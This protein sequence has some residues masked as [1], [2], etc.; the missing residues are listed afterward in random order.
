MAVSTTRR[1][2]FFGAGALPIGAHAASLGA[3]PP[4]RPARPGGLHVS[5]TTDGAILPGDEGRLLRTDEDV[6]GADITLTLP[7]A[8]A[9]GEGRRIRVRKAGRSHFTHIVTVAGDRIG[10]DGP[11]FRVLG[12]AD[13]GAGAIRLKVEEN[14]V[15]AADTRVVVEGVRGTVEANGEWTADRTPVEKLA[16]T[17][18]DLQGSAFRSPYISG[19]AV[20]VIRRRIS[21]LVQDQWI[22]LE[23][24]GVDRWQFFG[25]PGIE[26]SRDF[27]LGHNT[28]TAGG[29]K[30]FGRGGGDGIFPAD[31]V[32]DAAQLRLFARSIM[33]REVNDP[34]DLALGRIQANDGQ[35]SYPYGPKF[36]DFSEGQNI[37]SLYWTPFNHRIGFPRVAQIGCRSAEDHTPETLGVQLKMSVIPRG[38]NLLIDRLW[39]DQRFSWGGRS[40]DAAFNILDAAAGDTVRISNS[41]PAYSGALLRAVTAR[42]KDP[43]FQLIRFTANGDDAFRVDGAGNVATDGAA[44]MSTPADYA[45]MVREWWDG[46]PHGEDRAGLAVV[47][48]RRDRPEVVVMPGDDDHADSLIRPARTLGDPAREAIIGVVSVNPAI[49]G[50]SGELRWVRKFQTDPFGR[51]LTDPAEMVSWTEHR[52]ENTARA[53]DEPAFQAEAT[54]HAYYLDQLPPGVS[55]PPAPRGTLDEE[56]AGA[57][58]RILALQR[59]EAQGDPAAEGRF[60][61]TSAPAR[62][63]VA[64]PR[65]N[66]AFDPAAEYQGREQRR[67]WDFVGLVGRLPLRRGEPR[68]PRW[69]KTGDITPEVAEWLVR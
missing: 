65:L 60:T 27:L 7:P 34:V 64:R 39:I 6:R 16:L 51:V 30:G 56:I 36:S 17:H 20:T 57:R 10:E 37:G 21:L 48:V 55:V 11:R 2:M 38:S 29:Y 19:G 32:Y 12:A 63:P 41:S 1:L 69:I 59:G 26:G 18:I 35:G 58:R 47:L 49:K 67:E 4:A 25:S 15:I 13:D 14:R 42:S 52:V 9:F 50:A 46:N 53:Q 44:S 8:A 62:R 22:E 28:R 5:R 45:E 33:L 3:P 24:N 43:G 54:Q 68:H 66:P 31:F 40:E 23:S 61:W